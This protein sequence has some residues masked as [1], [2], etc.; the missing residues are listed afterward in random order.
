[1]W[2]AAVRVL[3]PHGGVE[4]GRFARGGLGAA[5]EGAPGDGGGFGARGGSGG[6]LSGGA[7]GPAGTLVGVAVVPVFDDA[8]VFSGQFGGFAGLVSSG[9]TVA[10]VVSSVP[11]QDASEQPDRFCVG[12]RESSGRFP[13]S[14]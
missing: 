11:G 10:E 2:L 7:A 12:C 13:A 9:G 14:L 1:V 3:A 4:M 8:G 5:F 6:S